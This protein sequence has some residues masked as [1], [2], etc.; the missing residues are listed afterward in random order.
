MR[1]KSYLFLIGTIIFTA[2]WIQ[3]PLINAGTTGKGRTESR[4]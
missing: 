2:A 3:T 1:M 4:Q